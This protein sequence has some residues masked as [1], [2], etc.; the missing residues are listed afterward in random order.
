MKDRGMRTS[1]FY[2]L[3][4][5]TMPAA[6]LELGFITNPDDSAMLDEHP[7][8]FAQGIYNGILAHFNLSAE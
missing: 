6:L 8:L 1:A 2:V 5:A 7:E 4:Y 3:K